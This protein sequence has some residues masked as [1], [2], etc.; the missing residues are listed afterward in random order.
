MEN[1]CYNCDWEFIVDSDL[2]TVKLINGD[3]G[4]II[5]LMKIEIIC[6]NCKECTSFN[7]ITTDKFIHRE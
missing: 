2:I 7:F 3:G 5:D 1:F 4:A 6:P